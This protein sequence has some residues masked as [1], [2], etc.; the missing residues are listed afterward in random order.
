LSCFCQWLLLRRGVGGETIGRSST[1]ACGSC[2]R[3]R[4]GGIFLKVRPWKTC[5]ERLRRQSADG[6]WDRILTHAQVYDDGT[7][8]EWVVS[9]DSLVVRA[10]QHAAGV[11]KKGEPGQP[12]QVGVIVAA[13]EG[14][15]LGCSQGGLSTKIRLA[16]DG[17]GRPLS[18][19]LTPGPAG[20]NPQLLNPLD[21]ISVNTSE[22]GRPCK[23]PDMLITDKAYTH[24]STRAQLRGRGIRHTIPRRSGPGQGWQGAT[25]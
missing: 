15:A 7:P 9:V 6:T 1:G 20:G 19:L 3:V 5:H 4:C 18:I 11:R 16:V 21:A 10:H 2:A 17:R 12:P 8:V 22:P 13:C 25:W 14:A 24:D 23:R